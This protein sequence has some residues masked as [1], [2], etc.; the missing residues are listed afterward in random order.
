MKFKSGGFQGYDKAGLHQVRVRERVLV[1]LLK[2]VWNILDASKLS[3]RILK[4]IPF[5]LC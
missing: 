3:A 1:R 5:L 4:L 2:A